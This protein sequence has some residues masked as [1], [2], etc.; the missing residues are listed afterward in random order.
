MGR[1]FVPMPRSVRLPCRE[2]AEQAPECGE[3]VIPTRP[4][5]VRSRVL[6]DRVEHTVA[7]VEVPVGTHG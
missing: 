2:P 5:R 7:I 6:P 3:V 1:P 4:A